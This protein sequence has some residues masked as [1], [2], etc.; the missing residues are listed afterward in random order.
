MI[1]VEVSFLPALLL[2]KN[3]WKDWLFTVTGT[4][5]LT[6]LLAAIVGIPLTRPGALRAL[7]IGLWCGYILFCLLFTYHIRYA[8]YYHA[9]LIPIVAISFSSIATVFSHYI[10]QMSNRWHWSFFT[11]LPFH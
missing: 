10:R 7:L 8:G 11:L 1:Q 2:T 4:I 9:Q 6:P 3:F 5:G